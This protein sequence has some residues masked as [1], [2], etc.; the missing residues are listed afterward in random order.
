MS[1]YFFNKIWHFERKDVDNA[2]RKF[3]EF[4]L[5]HRA[6]KCTCIT[7]LPKAIHVTYIKQY[8]PI[9]CYIVLY[10]MI[11]KIIAKRLQVVSGGIVN[12]GQSRFIHNRKIL[13]NVQLAYELIKG[14]GR[15]GLSSRCIKKLTK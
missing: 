5:L 14:Y 10:K 7:L 2:V 3:F 15:K 13:D 9:S 11:S 6:M 8:R 4:G 1:S 12:P